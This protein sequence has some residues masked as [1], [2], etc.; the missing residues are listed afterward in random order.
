MKAKRLII[1]DDSSPE[2]R[3]TVRK[4]CSS[5]EARSVEKPAKSKDEPIMKKS[6]TEK[7]RS[8]FV[9]KSQASRRDKGKAILNEDIPLK[10]RDVP[11]ERTQ[12]EG[13]WAEAAEVLTM[14]LDTEEDPMALEEVAAKAVEDV[15]ATESEPQKVTSP[16]TSTDTIILEKGKEPS[17]EETQSATLGAIDVLSVQVLPLLQYLDR[18]REKYAEGN[19][20][21]SYVEIVRNWTRAKRELALE[22]AAKERRSQSTEAK[23]QALQRK[24]TAEV[25]RRR[26]AE[27]AGDSLCEDVERAKCA[28]VRH[29]VRQNL[30]KRLEACRTAY[31]AESSEVDE[32]QAAAEEAKRE[33]QAELAINWARF[34]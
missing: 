9:E 19:P 22:F 17:A 21:E 5:Q 28:S 29:L 12:R 16:R 7:G 11:E 23:Y 15:A 3:R 31:D 32:L 30:M 14:S 18:K 1:D 26:K 20:S 33:Y 4:N 27:Q 24:L 25:E 2:S 8:T 13:P 6:C 10:R 34:Q